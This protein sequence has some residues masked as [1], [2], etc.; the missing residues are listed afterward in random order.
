M[1]QV[2]ERAPWLKSLEPATDQQ[3]LPMILQK[4]GE[5]MDDFV[6]NIGDL[7]AREDLTQERLNADGKIK[8]KQQL[9]DNYLILHHSY[10]WGASAEYRMDD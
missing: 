3:E 4:M 8:A 6:H 2:V 10:S 7:I 1:A 5:R 9:Q